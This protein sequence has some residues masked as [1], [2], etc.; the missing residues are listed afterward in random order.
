MS[1]VTRILDQIERGQAEAAD[2]LPLVYAELRRLAAAKMAHEREGQTLQPT[3][4]VHEAWIKLAGTDQ[5]WN[6]QGHFFAA[7]AEAMRRILI[8]RA[9]RRNRLRHGAGLR[10]IRLDDVDLAVNTPDETLLCLEEALVK[11]AE[12]SPEKAKLVNLRFFAGLNMTEAA[13]ALGISR[14]T[15][16]RHW[17][18]A[19]AWLLCELGRKNSQ[20]GEPL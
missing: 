18:Y 1:E 13:K 9:R 5:R 8:D 10:R 20:P 6:H 16:K 3:A 2:L 12:E 17:A 15:A 19:R 7:A 11:F 14:A 4:L